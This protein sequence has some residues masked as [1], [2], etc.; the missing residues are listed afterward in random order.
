LYYRVYSDNG[1][2]EINDPQFSED[3]FLGSILAVR[4]PPPHSTVS[5]KRCLCRE[6]GIFN[7]AGATLFRDLSCIDPL[8]DNALVEVMAPSGIGHDREEPIALVIPPAESGGSYDPYYGSYA[9]PNFYNSYG[10]QPPLG[11][12]VASGVT[13]LEGYIYTLKA[14]VDDAGE[15]PYSPVR[16][17]DILYTDGNPRPVYGIAGVATERY[18]LPGATPAF[19]AQNSRTGEVGWVHLYVNGEER[20][21]FIPL[22]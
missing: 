7:V 10:S 2:K 22:S 18:L 12:P 13:R 21:K 20:F 17:G 8:D 4:I 5:V 11:V 9:I 16:R 1:A 14:L 19:T 6:E 15:S 3:P